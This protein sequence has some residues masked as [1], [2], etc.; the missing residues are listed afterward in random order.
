M[1]VQSH[2]LGVCSWSL[3]ANSMH[4][5]V[6]ITRDLGLSHIQLALGPLVFLDDKQK[7]QELGHLRSSGLTI[8]AGMISFPGEDYSTIA[9]IRATGGYL[10]DE[11]WEI[12]RLIT[13]EAAKLTRE[14]GVS[15]LTT[16]IGFIPQ[17]NNPDYAK[18]LERLAVV[19]GALTNDGI[20]LAMETGQE[21]ASELLQFLNDLPAR[22]LAVNFDPANMIL[23]GSGDPIHAVRT[24]GRHIRHVHLKDAVPS[25]KPMLDWGRQTPLGQGAVDFEEFFVALNDVG[26]QGPLVIEQESRRK[27]VEDIR[28]STEYL[29]RFNAET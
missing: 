22:N 26:Y 27:R 7:H 21:S 5:L 19:A 3:P 4:E 28:A 20:T 10:P 29:K 11:T 1:Q 8:T 12:R 14:L 25:E 9:R 17:S 24:L 2:D 15:I 16:H 13:T 6:E 18:L 23:Y